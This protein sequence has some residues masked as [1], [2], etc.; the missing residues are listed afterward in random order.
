MN[1][2]RPLLLSSVLGMAGNV[3]YAFGK[4]L[5]PLIAYEG[6]NA[7]YAAASAATLV[8]YRQLFNTRPFISL[9][10]AAVALLTCLVAYFHYFVD[11]FIGRTC[12]A[13]LFQVGIA[14][15]IG[16][17]V[18]Q[19]RDEGEQSRYARMFILAMCGLVAGGH[20]LRVVRQCIVS[21]APKSLL[22]P[23][24]WN[25]FLLSGGAFVLPVLI[26]GGLLLAHRRLISDVQHAANHDFL[27]GAWSRR[28]FFDAG[29]REAVRAKRHGKRLALL[30][31][32]LD[33]LKPVNDTYGH[34]A[35][36]EALIAFVRT[37]QTTLRSID[38]LARLGGDEFAI[39]MPETDLSGAVSAAERLKS[40][41]K[42]A[43]GA[44]QAASVTFSI[45]VAVLRD[46]DSFNTLISRADKALYEA[47]GEGRD[48]VMAQRDVDLAPAMI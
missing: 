34:A 32:D 39:L 31:I 9:L 40:R 15:G 6:A 4:E 17:T 28:A 48:R 18:L 38:C 37:A 13:S 20:L 27:T 36:D 43:G 30:L 35:G 10:A 42:S 12:V 29:E 21:D 26:L 19:A 47:K 44:S 45:G 5:P 46:D 7:V 33:N 25:V 1:G 22:E 16:C 11:S 8:G 24:G 23:S 14:A 3:L 2:V 41:W